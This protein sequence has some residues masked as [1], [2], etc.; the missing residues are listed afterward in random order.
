MNVGRIYSTAM[1][2]MDNES[3]YSRYCNVD[4]DYNPR[5]AITVIPPLITLASPSCIKV[6]SNITV[7]S[8]WYANLRIFF[9][10]L[11][12]VVAKQLTT[13]IKPRK[14]ILFVI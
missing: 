14:K 11:Y 9:C 10:R 4:R 5:V 2:R 3:S 7:R 12:Y 8:I 6:G 13:N 1:R